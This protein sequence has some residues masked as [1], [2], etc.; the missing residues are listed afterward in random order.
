MLNKMMRLIIFIFIVMQLQAATAQGKLS[1]FDAANP[2]IQYT[3]RIDFSNPIL[4]RFW[5]P[6][7]YIDVKFSGSSCEVILNDEVLW[8]TNH[9]YIEVVVDGIATR[10]QTKKQTDTIEVAKGLPDG[11]HT[12]SIVKNTEANIGY[13]ELVGIRCKQLLKPGNKPQHKIE[14]IGDSIT[15][16]AS[17]DASSVPCHKGLWHDQHNAY[18]SYGAVA[19]RSLK[20][21]YHLSSVSGIGL[22]HSCCN[23]DVIMPPVY[24]KISMRNNAIRWDFT[25][26]VPDVVTVCLGQND[27][28]Q[29]SAAFCDNYISFVKQLRKYYPAATI[30]CLSS[31]MADESLRNFMN[32]VL[33]AITATF[34]TNGDKKVFTYIFTKQYYKGCDSHPDLNEHRQIA[35]E[36]TAFIQQKMN[37]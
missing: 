37:W 12:L 31:P 20:A 13:L 26:Y 28:I 6:G 24:D 33:P 16:G 8:G 22:M 34:N 23:M 27:G 18:L 25:I 7:V 11:I 2:Y 15:C 36:V 4:P 10:L 5:Q 1:F 30:I 17:A 29:D 19:A 3:G 35:N 21:Q 14:F 32:K 9:N